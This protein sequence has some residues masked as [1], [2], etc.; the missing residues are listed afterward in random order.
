MG[1]T[2]T[3]H[4]ALFRLPFSVANVLDSV[5]VF[6]GTTAEH[7]EVSIRSHVQDIYHK[8]RYFL[9]VSGD[10]FIAILQSLF[11]RCISWFTDISIQTFCVL[12]QRLKIPNS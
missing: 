12:F 3:T 6:S 10:T 1:T 2:E 7:R 11:G 5:S 4:R 9:C 8:V